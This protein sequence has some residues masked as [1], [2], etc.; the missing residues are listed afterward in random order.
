MRQRGFTLIE[1][2][3]VIA[4]VGVISAV[5]VVNLGPLQSHTE[6]GGS[7]EQV[8][9][10]VHRTRLQAMVNRRCTQLL[11]LDKQ[12]GQAQRIV[13]RE[14][15]SFDCEGTNGGFQNQSMATAP[16]IDNA[17]PL[18]VEID[19]AIFDNP[20]TEVAF[21]NHPASLTNADGADLPSTVTTG[22]ELR[23]RPTGRIWSP[24]PTLTNDNV[25]LEITHNKITL[26][27]S[28]TLAG[29]GVIQ[30]LPTGY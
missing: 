16:K 6:L 17:K 28:M 13:A 14:L 15:N 29:N 7:T 24:D 18:W 25:T 26:K 9:G 23:F 3:L 27:K 12:P 8:L 1:V 11:L 5:A 22:K 2:M 10:M 20:R 21:V 30:T 4:I 19:R